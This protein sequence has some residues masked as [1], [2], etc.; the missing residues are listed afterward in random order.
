M[1]IK[2]EADLLK[3]GKQNLE[4]INLY[5]K[6]IQGET[7]FEYILRKKEFKL[8][9]LIANEYDSYSI[10]IGF[11]ISQISK[12]DLDFLKETGL[13]SNRRTLI[14]LRDAIVKK[15]DANLLHKLFS[16][17]GLS[18]NEKIN[19]SRPLHL[20]VEVEKEDIVKIL[21]EHGADVNVTNYAGL[22]PLYMAVKRQHKKITELL[23]LLKVS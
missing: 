17:Y 11:E 13:I 9:Q 16:D 3:K 20:A 2:K 19:N 23:F 6:D 5:Q 8:A 18:P 12:E 4:K 22:M 15:K 7:P 10:D 1:L 21:L 14:L